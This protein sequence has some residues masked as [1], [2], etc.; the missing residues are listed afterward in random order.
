MP[1]RVK[2]KLDAYLVRLKKR[3]GY[4]GDR[5]IPIVVGTWKAR[6]NWRALI[7]FVTDADNNTQ[8]IKLYYNRNQLRWKKADD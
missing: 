2:D 7:T 4:G 3:G 1:P 8:T 6:L 5:I